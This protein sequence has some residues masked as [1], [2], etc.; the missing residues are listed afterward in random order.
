MMDRRAHLA[1]LL[2]MAA[3]DLPARQLQAMQ[4]VM[5]DKIVP[6]YGLIGQMNAKPGQRAALAAILQEGTAD[7]PANL[8]YLVGKDM[9][10]AD[11]LWIVEFWTDKDAHA[12]SLA[13]PQVRAAITKARPILTGF[14]TRAEF[15]PLF[16]ESE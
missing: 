14:G 2:V 3:M 15:K 11:A 13:L 5:A 9:V 1:G 12:A 16:D 8:S 10:N 6:Q 7:M 4:D